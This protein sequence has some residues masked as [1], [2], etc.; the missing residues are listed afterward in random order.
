MAN[1][2]KIAL[3]AASSLFALAED[4]LAVVY[5]ISTK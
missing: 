1:Q 2:R 3:F 4:F 5:V